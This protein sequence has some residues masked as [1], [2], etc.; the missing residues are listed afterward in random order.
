MDAL[1]CKTVADLMKVDAQKLVDTAGDVLLLRIFPV[2]DGRILPFDPYGAYADGAAK[3]I[4]F[5]QGGFWGRI[6]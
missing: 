1:G 4:A 3:N 2:R 5:L 6:L